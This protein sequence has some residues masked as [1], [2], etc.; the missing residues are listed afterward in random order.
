M[1]TPY[2]IDATH[3]DNGKDFEFS[4]MTAEYLEESL[5]VLRESFFPHEAVHKVL[6]MSKNPLA[7]EEE[8]K[9]CRKTFEDGVS[10]IAREKA[11]GKIVTVAFCKMQEKPKPGEQ[12]AFDE[13]AAS[14]KQ[15]ES[16]G[17][18][19]FM[20]QVDGKVDMFGKYSTTTLYE[21]MF[22]GTL[23]EYCGRHLALDVSRVCLQVAGQTS[24]SAVTILCTS[25]WTESISKGLG[26][27]LLHKGS[28]QDF[29]T[30]DG[31]KYSDVLGN[32]TFY[33]LRAFPLRKVTKM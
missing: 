24:A 19:D 9:L 15:P 10:V 2:T 32:E 5:A 4:L 30:S 31:L 21:L 27:E 28:W 12:G 22:L 6:G 26:F 3:L 8:E 14:F 13:I 1:S 18:M 33:T 23:P 7:V 20:I 16:L 29:Q 11:S 25:P 17:V